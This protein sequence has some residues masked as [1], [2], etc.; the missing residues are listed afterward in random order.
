M[1][2][3][4]EFSIGFISVEN[5][6][7]QKFSKRPKKIA[8]IPKKILKSQILKMAESLGNTGF[9]MYFIPVS[10]FFIIIYVKKIKN[11]YRLKNH[12]FCGL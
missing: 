3:S 4:N 9:E 1:E 8:K 7:T 10:H 6:L 5:F 12:F 11:I 2:S